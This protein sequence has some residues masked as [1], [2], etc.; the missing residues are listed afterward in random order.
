M[1]QKAVEFFGAKLGRDTDGD[2]VADGTD[3]CRD[4][5]NAD[6]ADAD[7]DGIGDVCDG[8]RDGDDVAN[9][10]DNCPDT[11]NAGQADADHDG[12]GDACYATPLGTTPPTLP[13]VRFV[14]K[15]SVKMKS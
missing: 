6:Q 11:A 7:H 13:T 1:V 3:N 4:A 12:A 14:A 8:D 2:D 5:A 9:G 15:S 10:A